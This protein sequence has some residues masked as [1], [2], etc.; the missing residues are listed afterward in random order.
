MNGLYVLQFADVDR[1]TVF[2][3]LAPEPQ[4]TTGEQERIVAYT[5]ICTSLFEMA[6]VVAKAILYLLSPN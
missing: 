5:S 4:W 1:G 3:G 6:G 2:L